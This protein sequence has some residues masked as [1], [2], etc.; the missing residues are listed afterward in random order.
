[1]PPPK[2]IWTLSKSQYDR[3]YSR[4]RRTE[5]ELK[6]LRQRNRAWTYN[7]LR[8]G[9]E[10]S[11]IRIARTDG[12]IP[13]AIRIS[14]C[15]IIPGEGDGILIDAEKECFCY[16]DEKDIKL[17]NPTCDSFPP[18]FLVGVREQTQCPDD[19]E[20]WLIISPIGDICP[21]PEPTACPEEAV[22]SS[23]DVTASDCPHGSDCLIVG[24]NTVKFC[25]EHITD[26]RLLTLTTS[27]VCN[28][29]PPD[30]INVC[31]WIEP[32][33]FFCADGDSN[34]WVRWHLCLNYY[35]VTFTN[36]RD[37]LELVAVRNVR[38]TDPFGFPHGG[39]D[40]VAF[41]VWEN[42]NPT[43]DPLDPPLWLEPIK[44]DIFTNGID[45][46]IESTDSFGTSLP[47][48]FWCCYSG[49]LHVEFN[50]PAPP[51]GE[52]LMDRGGSPLVDRFGDPLHDRP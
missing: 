44:E 29:Q 27:V 22:I 18:D 33:E 30:R 28:E 1:M 40:I 23:V 51:A 36:L 47:P 14:S 45:L 16:K 4:L 5:V 21:E 15:V 25:P 9:G 46:P 41:M 13:P 34:I 48:E 49:T 17:L 6:N 7:D 10:G 32:F 31:A 38:Y 12:V 11:L 24:Q 43:P 26:D 35:P 8:G 3:L 20:R 2:E 37:R 52:P 42:P 39:T 50:T 19:P